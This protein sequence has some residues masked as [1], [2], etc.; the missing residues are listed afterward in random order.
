MFAFIVEGGEDT[1]ISNS[2]EIAGEDE[3]DAG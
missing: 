3:I 2:V 1:M